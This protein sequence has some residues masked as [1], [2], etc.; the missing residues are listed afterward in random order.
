MIGVLEMV[1]KGELSKRKAAVELGTS[2]PTINRAM[3]WADRYG[4]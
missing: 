1:E 3:E 4:L 2:R